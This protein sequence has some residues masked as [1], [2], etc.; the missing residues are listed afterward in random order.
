MHPEFPSDVF[1]LLET[2]GA[3]IIMAEGVDQMMEMSLNEFM[4]D[5]M[6]MKKRILAGVALPIINSAT[7]Q[8]VTYK[9]RVIIISRNLV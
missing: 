9:V 7:N 1:I 5:A 3:R 8:V 6:D 4:S 2:I